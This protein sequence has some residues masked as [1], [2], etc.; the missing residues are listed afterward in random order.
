MYKERRRRIRTAPHVAAFEYGAGQGL[1]KA[2]GRDAGRYAG[3][4]HIEDRKNDWA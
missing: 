3:K 2:A 4:E 1:G